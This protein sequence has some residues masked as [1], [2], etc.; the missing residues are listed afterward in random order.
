MGSNGNLRRM[1]TS[2]EHRSTFAATADVVFQTLVDEAFLSQRLRDIGGKNAALLDHSR[3][4][5]RVTFR[6]R[7]GVDASRLPGAVRSMLN[8][9]LVVEREER[10]QAQGDGYAGTSR[11]SITGVPGEIEGR[12][13]IAG[14]DSGAT[15]V[16]TAQVRVNIPLIGGRIE[17][18][19]AE[20]VAK[21][22]AT[23]GEYADKWLADRA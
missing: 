16:I 21:L 4:G 17:K 6:M 20:Q 12:S 23:E 18:T 10:W 14:T 1:A 13:R 11:V 8:G 22:L 9:D 15:L 2:L 7:Q 5:D 3:D 19:V